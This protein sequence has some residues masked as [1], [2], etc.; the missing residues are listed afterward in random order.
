MFDSYFSKT[1][2]EARSRFTKAASM[3]D[4]EINSYRI[5]MDSKLDLAIGRSH[6]R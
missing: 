6:S 4:A 3:A 5:G 1:Y 2:S